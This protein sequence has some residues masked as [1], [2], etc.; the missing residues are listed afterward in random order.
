M[1]RNSL[2]NDL[3][4]MKFGALKVLKRHEG[5]TDIS[6]SCYWIC[7]CDCGNIVSRRTSTLKRAS[8]GSIPN[9]GCLN[10]KRLKKCSLSMK[11]HGMSK[12]RIFG[13]W[14]NMRDRCNNPNSQQYYLYGERGIK[15]C[16]EWLSDFLAFYNWSIKN[17]YRQGLS[18]DRIDVNGDYEP[19]NCRWAT[20]K[21]QIRNRRNTVYVNIGGV[22][23][24]LGELSEEYNIKYNTLYG[25]YRR[26]KGAS[27]FSDI[28]K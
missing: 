10:A 22:R 2:Y 3:T 15:V 24:T 14:E 9:C 5:K 4:G 20:A 11:K 7:Q 16:K 17:G 23:K 25:R 6:K 27:D 19:N 21:Q 1:A 28:I 26:H 8:K 13:I 18:I 12:T